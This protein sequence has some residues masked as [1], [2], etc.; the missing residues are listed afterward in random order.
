MKE[1][2]LSPAVVIGVIVV[3]VVVAAAAIWQFSGARRTAQVTTEESLKHVPTG[4]PMG[5]GPRS[6]GSGP[7]GMPRM[8]P[9][10][11]G[12]GGMPRMGP[13]GGMGGSGR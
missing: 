7:G 1:N 2:K 5:A 11:G 10:G 12:P 4:K 13:P 3:V 9:P 8:G 6:G